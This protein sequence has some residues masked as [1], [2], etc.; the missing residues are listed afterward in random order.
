MRIA[1]CDDC[2]EDALYL[3]S[4]LGRQ[5][6]SVYSDASSLLSDIEQNNVQYDLYLLDIYMDDFAEHPMNGMD[7]ARRIR[8]HEE[9]SIICF[10]SSSNAFYREAYDIYAFQYLL[11][12]V[13]PDEL[14]LLLDKVSQRLE[15]NRE[16]KF[17]YRWRGQT[18]SIPYEKILFISS[19][20]H[21]VLIQCKDGLEQEF[22]GK[23]DEIESQLR[24]DVF[25]RCHQ[26]FLVNIYQ[27]DSLNRNEMMVFGH[28]VPVSRRYYMN[29][30]KRYQEVLFEEV[31]G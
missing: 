27:V 14:K 10:I 19:R 13:R 4:F 8:L 25:L 26:S 20:E 12:P 22:K 3:K 30:K 16:Q 1:L 5:D 18:K 24:G 2:R 28:R 17:F 15:R 23:L 11:K 31:G 7:L 6:V 29:V 21:T 9:E